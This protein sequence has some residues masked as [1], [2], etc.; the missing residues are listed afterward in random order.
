MGA[1]MEDDKKEKEPKMSVEEKLAYDA[2]V[3]LM[4]G[5]IKKY[6]SDYKNKYLTDNK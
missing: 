4:A 5:L 3:K 6:G 2:F 1:F